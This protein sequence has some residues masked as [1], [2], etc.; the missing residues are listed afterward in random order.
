MQ[1]HCINNYVNIKGNNS[2]L[3][4]TLLENQTTTWI[5]E[6]IHCKLS[7]GIGKYLKSSEGSNLLQVCRPSMCDSSRKPDYFKMHHNFGDRLS[8]LCV[9]K[10]TK[11]L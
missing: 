6:R 5:G 2:S 3:T 1:Y 9:C 7:Y 8:I 4:C 11:E 10:Q